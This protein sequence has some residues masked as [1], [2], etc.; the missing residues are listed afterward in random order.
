MDGHEQIPLHAVWKQLQ[1]AKP[2]IS[3]YASL[4]CLKCIFLEGNKISLMHEYEISP[5]VA[6]AESKPCSNYDGFFLCGQASSVFW[7]FQS[8]NIVTSEK[9]DRPHGKA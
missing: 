4:I 8:G 1:R 9:A 6:P 7:L 3:T 2:Q 5:P